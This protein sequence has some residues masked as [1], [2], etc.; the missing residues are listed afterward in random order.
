MAKRCR[1]WY[2]IMD[3]LKEWI[4]ENKRKPS[5]AT[6]NETEK[7]L[8]T[9][10]KCQEKN[11]K[12][13]I[14]SMTDKKK[15]AI[16]KEF[17]QE[18]KEYVVEQ[19]IKWYKILE[20][21]KL[22]LNEHKR[23]PSSVAVDETEKRLGAWVN[24]QQVNYKKNLNAMSNENKRFK[25]N[26]CV[27]EHREYMINTDTK[28]Y[29]IFDELTNWIFDNKKV[30]SLFSS[31]VTEKRLAKWK[32]DQ[33]SYYIHKTHMMKHEDKRKKW[34]QNIICNAKWNDTFLKLKLWIRR[35]K[36]RPSQ[37]S[38]E[39]QE[40]ALAAW[41]NHQ[42]INYKKQIKAMKSIYIRT[43]WDDFTQTHKKYIK[44]PDAK[45]YNNFDEVK[46]WVSDNK[47]RPSALSKNDHEKKLGSWLNHQ[48][49]SYKKTQFL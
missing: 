12:N 40:K 41:L 27:Q 34:K 32:Y 8:G 47:K 3:E 23:K 37:K 18:Y 39:E 26:E 42:Q 14:N 17:V 9:W 21:L 24:Q 28:W 6:M 45:W 1:T 48:Q 4:D 43:K 20:E 44:D 29:D 2:D 13:N 15:K 16:W 46:I 33:H 36:R 10:I 31:D 30:P 35:R 19:S 5:S 11:Y 49:N 25:W 22:W 7:R 38:Q